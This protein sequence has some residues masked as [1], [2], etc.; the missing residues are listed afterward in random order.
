MLAFVPL[1]ML[2]L[3]PAL[4]LLGCGL[5]EAEKHYNAGAEL[6]EQGRLE[7]AIAEYD[8][9]I[10]L[11]PQYVLAYFNRGVAYHGLGEFQ[12]AVEDLDEA[13]RLDPDFGRDYHN[14]GKISVRASRN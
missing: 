8:Q 11:D 4:G 7:E 1:V 5:S 14:R 12:Q 2:S 6:Q 13:I 3:F 9:A 10:R